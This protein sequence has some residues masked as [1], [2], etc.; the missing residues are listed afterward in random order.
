MTPLQQVARIEN[1]DI[2]EIRLDGGTQGR[3]ALDGKIV[4]EYSEL[5]KV[6]VEFPPLRAWF[7]G[8]SYWLVDGFQRVAAAKQV[9]LHT[10]TSEV[11]HG[12][13][14]EAQ[15]DS[16]AANA[17]HG[18]RRTTSDVEAVMK[19]A[20]A[21]PMSRQLSSNQIAQHLHLPEATF[22]RWKKRLSSSSDED[23]NRIA[24]RRGT[25]YPMH[26]AR[27]GKTLTVDT[28][29][30]RSQKALRYEL[31]TLKACASPDARRLIN[32]VG[33]WVR[34]NADPNSL[35]VAI[36]RVV[37][38]LS[39]SGTVGG[40]GLTVWLTG[41]SSAGMS[42]FSKSLYG[43][44]RAS[45]RN[46]EW[47]DG[48]TVRQYLSKGLGFSKQDRDENVRRIG[49]VAERLTRNGVITLVSAI[50]PYRSI[51]EE[52]RRRIGRFLEVYV[53]A[54]LATCEARDIKGVYRRARSG[55]MTEVTGID[56]PYEAPLQPDVECHTDRE[57]VAE[58]AKKVLDAI[59]LQISQSLTS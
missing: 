7:D 30:S 33:N 10:F 49:F 47:L 57:S 4:L 38:S 54:P 23:T 55:E 9:G 5:M 26:T 48:D 44:L 13:L 17:V 58:S 2:D 42:T 50:S 46:V 37:L 45:Y 32:I 11:L 15:W 24:V 59:H 43:Q 41:M 12:S 34:G 21:H 6:G 35:L 19:R 31:E 40:R 27:I 22:R 53:N 8:K 14:Q 1:L 18:I 20:L 52:V 3:V 29:Q 39:R 28:A 16:Y 36:E 56:S 25:S 51:R